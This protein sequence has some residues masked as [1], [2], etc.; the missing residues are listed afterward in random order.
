MF[1]IAVLVSGGGTDLQSVID[2]VESNYMNVKIEMVIGSRDNIY[3]LERAKKHNIDTFVVNRREYGEE[4]SNKILEL[5]KGKVDL[6]VLAGFLAILDGEILKEFDNR[7][8]NIHPSLI[9]SF[10]GPGMYGL[11]V[12][13]AV[14]KSG[15]RFSGC[16]VHFVNSEVDG[17]AILLQEVVP[18]YFEDD[19]ETLQ[20][21]I[22][23]K[24][25]EILP[26]AIKLISENKIRVIDGRVKIE[27]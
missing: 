13:E 15:V 20:K 22:L 27:E 17:G 19:A 5:T 3:A 23:E 18:V 7:I 9:P 11:K 12:H 26:K 21:R 14:I 16:T 2:A 24:E 4:S 1:K 10:C 8:I 6:I 25:H